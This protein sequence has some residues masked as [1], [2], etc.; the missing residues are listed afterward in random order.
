MHAAG[1]PSARPFGMPLPPHH[2]T[3]RSFQLLLPMPVVSAGVMLP[4]MSCRGSRSSASKAPPR[5]GEAAA[6]FPP[7]PSALASP[8]LAGG[9]VLHMAEIVK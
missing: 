3:L 9:R 6:A 8:A 5:L 4:L 1:L 2:H 7:G